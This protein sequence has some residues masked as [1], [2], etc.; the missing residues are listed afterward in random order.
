MIKN[1]EYC[2]LLTSSIQDINKMIDGLETCQKII[3]SGHLIKILF[4][5]YDAVGLANIMPV[6]SYEELNV[7]PKWHEFIKLHNINAHV[8]VNSALLRGLLDDQMA[9]LYHKP[10]A[11][12]SPLFKL[13]SLSVFFD[14]LQTCD[15]FIQL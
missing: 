5:Q 1:F 6:V 9:Q 8:C 14:A 15:Q 3:Q 12:I 10:C 11:T 7:I 2:I 4:L 13:S